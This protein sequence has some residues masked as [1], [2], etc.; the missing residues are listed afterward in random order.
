M[1]TVPGVDTGADPGSWADTAGGHGYRVDRCDRVDLGHQ[2]GSW[3]IWSDVPGPDKVFT[4]RGSA[5]FARH[6]AGLVRM[7]VDAG[8]FGWAGTPYGGLGQEI[9]CLRPPFPVPASPMPTPDSGIR[10]KPVICRATTRSSALAEDSSLLQRQNPPRI[11]QKTR[12]P[13]VQDLLP[14][15]PGGV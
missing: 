2:T 9:P 11:K 8:Q 13:A 3:D 5:L 4:V 14:C 12:L 1:V 15:P 6:V 10:T 7:L